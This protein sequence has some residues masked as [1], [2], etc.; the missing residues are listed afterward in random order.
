[1][2][3]LQI[4]CTN[5]SHTAQVECRI[6][7]TSQTRFVFLSLSSIHSSCYSYNCIYLPQIWFT[8][9]S[10]TLISPHLPSLSLLFFL[11]F[12]CTSKSW[13]RWVQRAVK[14]F[15]KKE[16]GPERD[17]SREERRV[18]GCEDTWGYEDARGEEI[19][20]LKMQCCH[21]HSQGQWSKWTKVC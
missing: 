5:W 3:H 9:V 21:L 11:S 13:K 14:F 20:G 18:R 6:C 8:T 16:R 2:E 12:P 1:M 10:L 19:G 7:S 15:S 4:H 17:V